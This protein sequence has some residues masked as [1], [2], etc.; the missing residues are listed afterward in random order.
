MPA[1]IPPSDRPSTKIPIVGIGAS[2]GGIGALEALFKA[3]PPHTGLAFVVIIHLDPGHR[4]ELA[5]I[6]SKSAGRP[7]VQ[8]ADEIAIEPDHV[9]VIPPDRELLVSDHQLQ[10]RPFEEPRGHR[11]PIDH[12]FRSLAT[13]H[14]DGFAVV[15]S[16]GGSD[17]AL[18]IRQVR[19]KGGLVLVQDPDEAE[20][21]SMPRA[22]IAAGADF[23]L[24]VTDIANHLV[25]LSR[26]KA[27]VN[28]R[29]IEDG[30]DSEEWVRRILSL[31]RARTGQDFSRYKRATVMRRLARRMQVAQSEQLEDYFNFL[32]ESPGEADAL[33][34]DLLISVTS[35]FRD[36]SAFEALAIDVIPRVF[37]GHG[38]DQS[39]R[40]WVTGCA[41]GEEAYSIAI[42]L[43]EEAARRDIRPD[44]Q[45]FATDLDEK[46]LTVAREGR[47]PSTIAA[48]VSEERLRRFFVREGEQYRI[49][50]EVRDLVVFAIHSILRD[51]PFSRI[52]LVTCR[53]LLIYLDRDLQQQ[54]CSVLHYALKPG[55][56]L[57]LGN[58]ETAE[59][60]TGLFTPVNREAR[61]FRSVE[62]ARDSLPMLPRAMGAVR[63]P[64]ISG[65][66]PARVSIPIDPSVHRLALEELTPPS[67]LVD[68]GHTVANLSETAGRFLLHPSGP[69]SAEASEIV[70][71]ELRLELKAALH[72]ALEQGKP[73]VTLPIPVQF[74]GGPAKA[75]VLHV[76]PVNRDTSRAALVLFLE[77]GDA[78]SG[79]IETPAGEPSAVVTQLREELLA[80]RTVLRTTREQYEAATEELRAA[81]E[82][83]QSINEEYRS[84]AEE[85]ETSKEELQSIN[86]E[87][88]TLNNE[89]K[90][91]LDMVSRAHNDLQ[92]LMSATD[93]S[94]MFL[95]SALRIQ[96]FTPRVAEIFNVQQGDEGR[97]VT[98]F[99]HKLDY[100]DLVSDAR[101]VLANLIPIE[102]TVHS[103][104]GRWYLIRL[105]PYRTLD[106]KIDGIVATFVD[107]TERREAEAEWHKRQQMLL[108]E[109]SHR[110]K[111]TL[112]VVQAIAMQ[113]LRSEVDEETL[114]VFDNR[115]RALALSHDLLVQSEWRGASLDALARQQ[116]GPYL[117]SSDQLSV[118]GPPV[119][120]P[121]NIATP[122][123]LVLHELAT[124]A[125]KYGS[126]KAA[127]GTVRVSWE[128]RE[129]DGGVRVL[130]LRWMEGG[131]SAPDCSNF[132]SGA[133]M[134]LIEHAIPNAT[135]TRENGETGLTYSLDVPLTQRVSEH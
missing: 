66:R 4:S 94:T 36:A 88:Q 115:L 75:V 104:P 53:N 20:F 39:I 67:M 28:A 8:V 61:I 100:N 112:A 93:V 18:G 80:T 129:L 54:V 82:E 86:E 33:F 96:R 12:F 85:L 89:L 3:L 32:R 41:T 106:D 6:L 10:V 37:D 127:A 118:S 56:Y 133:G 30:P 14:G 42:L 97:P 98:D 122:L 45:V 26:V 132:Q 99:T 119:I 92:N 101:T 52:D 131:V 84:T 114:S 34:N 43:L 116:L 120:L 91:K 65:P 87:L 103:T 126:L 72:R 40:V 110:V 1:S 76:S 58:S 124:N 111:N 13:S 48:D 51:P 16:G 47:Y 57:F 5:S 125:V 108:D 50:R 35:F 63:L 60:P 77:G 79:S 21:A 69:I 64:E 73:T 68:E 19:E 24:P 123:G 2:A 9:Y 107:V 7:V 55:G 121:P 95:D 23:V 128:T 70:R 29:S 44:I 78:D 27:H 134:K 130:N 11:A 25:E 74:N 62:R 46:A 90:L 102:R 17:G 135:V 15:L 105:R 38:E 109:L 83:L 59:S 31:L 113:T 81:N 71:P 117:N 49:R 22:A